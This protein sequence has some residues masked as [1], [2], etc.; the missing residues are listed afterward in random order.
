MTKKQKIEFITAGFL[1]VIF[2]V[3]SIKAVARI[4]KPRRPRSAAKSTAGVPADVV[5]DLAAVTNNIIS[6]GKA[7]LWKHDPFR[8]SPSISGSLQSGTL[9]LE[10]ILWDNKAP[11][12]IINGQI[13]KEGDNINNQKI[14]EIGTSFVIVNDGEKNYKLASE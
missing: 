13:L 8:L 9:H 7:L 12:A 10:G 5:Q 4:T 1:I 3:L 6:R 11:Y 14:I 2:L